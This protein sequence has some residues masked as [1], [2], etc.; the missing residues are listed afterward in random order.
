MILSRNLKC[1]SL[2][3]A[4]L[5]LAPAA[6]AA[7]DQQQLIDRARITVSDLRHDKEFG[8][9]PA[10]LKRAVAVMIVPQL[11]KGGFFV[12]GEGGDAVMLRREAHGW[13]NPAF[14]TLASASF[15]L[16]IGLEQSELVLFVLSEK[17]LHALLADQFKIGAGAGLAVVTLGSSAEAATTA[18]L[19]ADIVV[20]ASAS[21]AYAGVTLN[22]TAIKPRD[23][24]NM[25]YYHHPIS[26]SDILYRHQAHNHD[27][28][29]LRQALTA[30]AGPAS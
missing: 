14:Y 13:S 25:A 21:G 23:S 2:T 1:L 18:T 30:T 4:M 7:S 19:N 3:L 17:A 16:Q 8:T 10:L 20:W 27:A 29:R 12:G 6:W 24:A 9:A 28:D 15:G 22:G 5:L 26:V 11:V